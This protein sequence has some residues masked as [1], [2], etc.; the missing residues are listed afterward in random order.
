LHNKGENIVPAQIGDIG[1]VVAALTNTGPDRLVLL[2]IL[3]EI[4]IVGAV[5][6]ILEKAIRAMQGSS[7]TIRQ[8]MEADLM[9]TMRIGEM[10][11]SI[12]NLSASIGRAV[13]NQSGQLN[14]ALETLREVEKTGSEVRTVKEGIGK[15]DE[16]LN[17]LKD[18]IQHTGEENTERVLFQV[19]KL[20]A[21]LDEA[22]SSA[23]AG[24][25]QVL[26]AELDIQK[27]V[28]GARQSIIEALKSTGNMERDNDERNDNSSTSN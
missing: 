25:Q 28:E 23:R 22:E 7:E 27:A 4:L 3:A 2:I 12:A 8:K 6:W 11:T 15:I 19:S 1:E 5:L 13:E 24:I 16:S 14:I 20:F 17:H 21:R 9:Q 10:S 18:F 26:N